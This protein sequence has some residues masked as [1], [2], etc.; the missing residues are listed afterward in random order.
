[1]PRWYVWRRTV[2][3]SRRSATLLSL[4]FL[5][6][7]VSWEPVST[8]DACAV[9]QQMAAQMVS[10]IQRSGMVLSAAGAGCL[11]L[12]DPALPQEPMHRQPTEQIFR[13][14]VLPPWMAAH[15]E[16]RYA[17]QAACLA[18]CNGATVEA[19]SASAPGVEAFRLHVAAATAA[20]DRHLV[21]AYSRKQFL[22]TGAVERIGQTVLCV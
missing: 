1:V 14:A 10:P 19:V 6:S 12:A 13:A 22:Q 8:C 11:L 20:A 16:T 5:G 7:V 21:V 4:T 2:S 15:P 3:P 17:M 18:R 9:K